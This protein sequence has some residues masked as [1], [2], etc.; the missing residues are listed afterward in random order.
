MSDKTAKQI[1]IEKTAKQ[2]AE[3]VAYTI[4]HA[5][6]CT[7]TDWLDIGLTSSTL[8][9]LRENPSDRN[10]A[11]GEFA[12]DF[13]A[14]P[15]TIAMQRIL[16]S[17]M[18]K[19]RKL[20]EPIVGDIFYF[21]A[22]QGAKHWAE[23]HGVNLKSK[24]YKNRVDSIYNYEMEHLPQAVVW[25]ASAAGLNVAIMKHLDKTIPMWKL[26]T[27]KAGGSVGTAAL[28]MGGRSL[29]PRQAYKVDKFTSEHVFIPATKS[30]GKMFGIDSKD[31]DNMVKAHDNTFDGGDKE[32]WSDK[33]KSTENNLAVISR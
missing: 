16:P 28:V 10:I 32:K 30:F 29:F 20:A 13:G 4:N 17:V 22:E 11:I 5:L 2:K 26:L 7:A 9:R 33:V 24:E 3:D 1:E 19:I 21:G 6:V 12:G 23:E 14:V 15:I 25:S 18:Q 27:A 31:V 8:K